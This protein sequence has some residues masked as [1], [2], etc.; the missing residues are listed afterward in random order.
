MAQPIPL[1]VSVTALVVLAGVF[2][3]ASELR[4]KYSRRWRGRQLTIEALEQEALERLR[5]L[6]GEL[7]K[8]PS[9]TAKDIAPDKFRDE[10]QAYMEPLRSRDRFIRCYNWL[11][12]AATL[13]SVG[14]GVCLAG[15][16]VHVAVKAGV[17]MLDNLQGMATALVVSGF[18]VGVAGL[19]VRLVADHALVTIESSTGAYP[20]GD[21]D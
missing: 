16:A 8:S 13:M 20:S 14:S 11:L 9:L 2:W 4:D 19:L 7:S 1:G 21:D 12:R 18:V 5:A 10:V 17:K 6:Y 15:V 3:K